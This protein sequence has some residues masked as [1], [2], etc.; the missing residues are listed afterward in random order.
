MLFANNALE[1]ILNPIRK[2]SFQFHPHLDSTRRKLENNVYLFFQP[3]P[4]LLPSTSVKNKYKTIHP[5]FSKSNV[6]KKWFQVVIDRI[7]PT[8][9]SLAI[10]LH[11]FFCYKV[12]S[13]QLNNRHH[14][15]SYFVFLH[16]IQNKWSQ[17]VFIR[18][19]IIST[20]INKVYFKF[21]G[22]VFRN[23]F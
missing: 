17:F 1:H 16:S 5:V 15:C 4:V 12:L 3:T 20:S 7:F 21:F 13:P 8:L 2:A 11:L 18:T 9:F 23:I 6:F 10:T 19:S 22:Q 14:D